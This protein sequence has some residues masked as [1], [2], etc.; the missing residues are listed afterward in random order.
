M[1]DFALVGNNDTDPELRERIKRKLAANREA[2]QISD[3]EGLFQDSRDSPDRTSTSDSESG[4][5]TPH[6]GDPEDALDFSTTPHT[7]DPE[8]APDFS[9][10]LPPAVPPMPV[11]VPVPPATA[12]PGV[13]GSELTHPAQPQALR[14]FLAA[15]GL[16]MLLEK[17]SDELGVLE[18][19]SV[20][21]DAEL[22]EFAKG[23]KP[24][25]K[26]K[27]LKLM[28]TVRPAPGETPSDVQGRAAS[29][30]TPRP[31]PTP[32]QPAAYPMPQPAAASPAQPTAIATGAPQRIDL[33][34]ESAAASD[35]AAWLPVLREERALLKLGVNSRADVA[36]LDP[37]EARRLLARLFTARLLERTLQP[38]RL[39]FGCVAPSCFISYAWGVTLSEA[40]VIQLEADLSLAGIRTLLDLHQNQAGTRIRGPHGF[41]AELFRCD[42]VV[43]AGTRGLMH[44]FVQQQGVVSEELSN[45]LSRFRAEE[46]DM[47]GRSHPQYQS[48]VF[49]V[50][51]ETPVDD[52][53]PEE[54]RDVV[55]VD[56]NT[57]DAYFRQLFGLIAGLYRSGSHRERQDLLDKQLAEFE[58]ELDEFTRFVSAL[59]TTQ[60]SA[61]LDKAIVEYKRSRP[62]VAT[63]AVDMFNRQPVVTPFV[64]REKLLA[65]L[66]EAFEGPQHS[67]QRRVSCAVLHGAETAGKS[68][69][70]AQFMA[71][72]SSYRFRAWLRGGSTNQFLDD[73]W[74]LGVELGL[75]PEETDRSSAVKHLR[76]W[77]RD[78]PGWLLVIDAVPSALEWSRCIHPLLPNTGGHVLVTTR[79]EHLAP[80]DRKIRVEHLSQDE[81]VWLLNA[82]LEPTPRNKTPASSAST[83]GTEDDQRLVDELRRQAEGISRVAVSIKR[84]G[85]TVPDGLKRLRELGSSA[86]LAVADAGASATEVLL[87]LSYLDPK[88]IS[89]AVVVAWFQQ[90]ANADQAL[91]SSVAPVQAVL[92]Q[93]SR[94]GLLRRIT[95]DEFELPEDVL[96]VLRPRAAAAGF[97]GLVALIV[98]LTAEARRMGSA[99]PDAAG[100]PF[101][102]AMQALVGHMQSVKSV[103]L[104]AHIDSVH[105]GV[106]LVWLARLLALQGQAVAAASLVKEAESV[107]PLSA[108]QGPGQM[109]SA[110]SLARLAHCDQLTDALAGAAA[111]AGSIGKRREQLARLRTLIQVLEELKKRTSDRST[112]NNLVDG[113]RAEAAAHNAAGDHRH[114][115]QS[116]MRAV[117]VCQ[118]S[119]PSAG[120]LHPELP[121]LLQSVAAAYGLAGHRSSQASV[122]GEAVVVATQ[123]YGPTHP[124][125]GTLLFQLAQAYGDLG[126]HSERRSLLERVVAMRESA[127]GLADA[128]TGR[129][130]HALALACAACGDDSTRL[131]LLQRA[132]TIYLTAYGGYHPMV[133]LVCRDIADCH[134]ADR[135]RHRMLLH[136]ALDIVQ[137][138]SDPF[139]DAAMSPR[140]PGSTLRPVAGGA[141]SASA[142]TDNGQE[143]FQAFMLLCLAQLYTAP[144]EYMQHRSLLVQAQSLAVKALGSEHPCAALTAW[145]L[146]RAHGLVGDWDSQ[147]RM[148]LSVQDSY[149]QFLPAGHW[150]LQ[151]LE[152]QVLATA[153]TQNRDVVAVP[154]L[155]EQQPAVFDVMRVLEV[156]TVA[157]GFDSRHRWPSDHEADTLPIVAARPVV[158]APDDDVSAAVASVIDRTVEPLPSRADAA[159]AAPGST[160]T[161]PTQATQIMVRPQVLLSDVDGPRQAKRLVP[162]QSQERDPDQL[163]GMLALLHMKGSSSSSAS[164]AIVRPILNTPRSAP[165]QP[166]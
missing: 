102:P 92:D 27:F 144:E 77:L 103:A 155:A 42:F 67:S 117:A 21:D 88:C 55:F 85:G 70:A 41:T 160:A 124:F 10:V 54:L 107:A 152:Q 128:S 43:V 53:L 23:L 134:A 122:F 112:V 11:P 105:Y 33:R 114:E 90:R 93:L 101:T 136:S 75:F 9:S 40:K 30:S 132:R 35:V 71:D 94:G 81:G 135:L 39:A 129:A 36:P 115:V 34:Q 123:V 29:A 12:Q 44:K 19:D 63:G 46:N 118:Q 131:E 17:V 157:A 120:G 76:L 130:V 156:G 141:G 79:V 22:S 14:S 104:Q 61:E 56:M 31:D 13:P 111:V 37:S 83:G 89:L 137:R 58:R 5:P 97:P 60:L 146:A 109:P 47:S 20:L 69:L 166:L 149:R 138:R 48:T 15:V 110:A 84:S 74:S 87:A 3:S 113:L 151:Q 32:V 127:Q 165:G 158:A 106:M 65:A 133:A 50:L 78:Y 80:A 4:P 8:D 1:I 18:P 95:A 100:S 116:L 126:R 108:L 25:Q 26:A 51:F 66:R 125:V 82:H 154:P 45:I 143:K 121:P 52:C 7:G 164:T 64:K 99:S 119:P 148:L 57:P 62:L 162:S 153:N 68:Q 98:A 142:P 163:E 73:C 140:S 159:L 86:S 96:Q 38:V 150:Y 145:S 28:K 16:E 147:R 59:S 2:M 72:S 6:T 161:Q 49:P 91:G 139:E 24:V